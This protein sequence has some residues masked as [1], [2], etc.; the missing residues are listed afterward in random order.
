MEI[1]IVIINLGMK[2]S[3]LLKK[4]VSHLPLL[5]SLVTILGQNIIS[6]IRI[7]VRAS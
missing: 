7:I 6:H 3:Q 4:Y 1:T 5:V 2:S